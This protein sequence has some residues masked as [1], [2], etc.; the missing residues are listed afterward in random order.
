[1]LLK[2]KLTT[3]E[4]MVMTGSGGKI[5]LLKRM[6][7]DAEGEINSAEGKHFGAD[8]LFVVLTECICNTEVQ[9]E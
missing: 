8:L 3:R 6:V 1:M 2:G 9:D 7:Y 5:M 4:C